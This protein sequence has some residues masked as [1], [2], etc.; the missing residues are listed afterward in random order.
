M[1]PEGLGEPRARTGPRSASANIRTS[2]SA[3]IRTWCAGHGRTRR[4]PLD[5]C[6]RKGFRPSICPRKY[7]A[8]FTLP[9]EPRARTGPSNHFIHFVHRVSPTLEGRRREMQL[10]L[11]RVSTV[12]PPLAVLCVEPDCIKFIV[13]AVFTRCGGILQGEPVVRHCS[14][15]GLAAPRSG[16]FC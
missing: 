14:H 15:N 16:R 7:L 3:N 2:V 11:S 8:A 1:S 13:S 12:G 6:F 9:Q 10:S 5:I 4:Q